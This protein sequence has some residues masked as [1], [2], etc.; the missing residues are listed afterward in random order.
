MIYLIVNRDG[1]S[2]EG[3]D[4]EDLIDYVTTDICDDNITKFLSKDIPT[5]FTSFHSVFCS[6]NGSNFYKIYLNAKDFKSYAPSCLLENE[7][8]Y[9]KVLKVISDYEERVATYKEN[10]RLRKEREK[11]NAEQSK[12][13]KDR[14]EYE[15]LKKMFEMEN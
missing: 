9:N 3:Q 4:S 2:Y 11:K 5:L 12:L 10:E 8:E 15:R 1:A 6:D 7:T 13:E 14:I